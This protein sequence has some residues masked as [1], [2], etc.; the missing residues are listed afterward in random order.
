[1]EDNDRDLRAGPV[2][3]RARPPDRR[4]AELVVARRVGITKAAKLE[5]RFL[6]AGNPNVSRPRPALAR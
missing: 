4:E 3:I 2:V 1:M 5:W 6:E